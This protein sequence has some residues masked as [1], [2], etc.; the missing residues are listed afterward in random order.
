MHIISLENDDFFLKKEVIV[1][2]N[3]SSPLIF[4][5]HH[6]EIVPSAD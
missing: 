3:A 2:I 4:H 1:Q 5:I 6:K